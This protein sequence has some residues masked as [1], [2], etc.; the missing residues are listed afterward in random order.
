[1]ATYLGF[2]RLEPDYLAEQAA[3]QRESGFMQDERSTQRIMTLLSAIP[4]SV[5]FEGTFVPL[6]SSTRDSD[7]PAV[8]IAET[9][10]PSELM[11]INRHY[12]G[13]A[14]I[15]WVPAGAIRPTQAGREDFVAEQRGE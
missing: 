1:M 15:R 9:D 12:A 7:D 8:M 10:D 14:T 6:G 3:K 11:A 13:F 5:K 4:A 2:L